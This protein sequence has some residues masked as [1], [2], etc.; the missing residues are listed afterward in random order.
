MDLLLMVAGLNGVHG[1]VVLVV[2]VVL[3]QEHVYAILQNLILE[4]NHVS[5]L[6]V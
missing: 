3:E 5:V 4:E 2:M 6:I 1:H